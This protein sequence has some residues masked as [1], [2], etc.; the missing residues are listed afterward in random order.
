MNLEGEGENSNIKI[1]RV[2]NQGNISPCS[3]DKEMP[4]PYTKNLP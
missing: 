2:D 3:E 4:L 1:L